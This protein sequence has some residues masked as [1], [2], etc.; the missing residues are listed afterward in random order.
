MQI[1]AGISNQ[2]WIKIVNIV[3]YLLNQ[4][5]TNV[6]NRYIFF[7]TFINYKS[8]LNELKVFSCRAYTINYFTKLKKRWLFD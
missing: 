4:L 5:S 8:N 6:L 2:F 7:K 3:I 1:T